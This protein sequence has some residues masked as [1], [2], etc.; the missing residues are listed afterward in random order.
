M[1]EIIRT[2]F[3]TGSTPEQHRLILALVAW[4][5]TKAAVSFLAGKEVNLETFRI[6]CQALARILWGDFPEVTIVKGE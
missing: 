3:L 2:D 4:S 5:V 1:S 6:E